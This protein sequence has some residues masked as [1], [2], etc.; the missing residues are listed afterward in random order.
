MRAI[1]QAVVAAAAVATVGASAATTSSSH[2]AQPNL[3]SRQ[4]V[5]V[6]NCEKQKRLLASLL[7]STRGGSVMEEDEYDLDEYDEEE[8]DEYDLDEYDSE[9]EEIK[10][11]AISKSTVEKT[12]KT[13]KAKI[14]RAMK[15]ETEKKSLEKSMKKTKTL[16]KKKKSFSLSKFLRIPY[17]IKACLNPLTVFSMTKAYFASLFSIHYLQQDSSQTLRAALEEK[18][19]NQSA[20]GGSKKGRRAMRPGQAKTLSDLPQLSA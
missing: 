7:L 12:Q 2:F 13:Q 14:A 9:E 4:V 11:A 8:E 15:A 17:I 19:K 6:N 10:T 5:S 20:G 16:K 1:S 3:H 18:A